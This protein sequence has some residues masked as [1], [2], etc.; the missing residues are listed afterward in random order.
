VLPAA[1]RVRTR[2]DHRLVARTGCRV[3]RGALVVALAVPPVM[4]NSADREPRGTVIAGRRVGHAVVRN[5]VKRRLRELVR[6][7]MP[8]LPAGSLLVVRALPGA[9]AASYGQLGGW[10][11]AG[12]RSC[13]AQVPAACGGEGGGE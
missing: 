7:R 4:P 1:A 13:V 8:A 3:R 2:D 9:A 6:A 5:R 12:L 11:D 10:M